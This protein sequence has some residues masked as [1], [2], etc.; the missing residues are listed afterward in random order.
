MVEDIKIK[1]EAKKAPKAQARPSRPDSK[2]ATDRTGVRQLT[3]V[4]GRKPG[5]AVLSNRAWKKQNQNVKM[6]ILANHPLL[7]FKYT[8]SKMSA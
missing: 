1:C 3:K 6:P 4:I 5:I 2:V 8:D 7:F